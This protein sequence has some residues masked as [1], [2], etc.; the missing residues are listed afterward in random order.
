[1]QKINKLFDIWNKNQSSLNGWL[2]LSN[3]FTAE[4]MSKMGWDSITIDLQHGQND[5]SS[6]IS[7]L[8]AM[9][10]SEAT[11]LVRVPWN[12]PGIIM[13]MLDLG[14]LGVIA[15]MIN[16]KKDCENFVSYCNYP[17]IGQRS[18][19]PMRAQLIYGNEYFADA[20]KNIISFAMIETKEAV[21]NIDE[22]LSVKDL[23]GIYI[24]PADMSSAYG[25]KPKF[26]V[27]DDPVYSNIK[28]IVSKAN[29]MGKIAGIHNG[30]PSYAKE[31]IKLGFKFVTVSS[32]YRSMTSHAQSIVNEMKEKS[33]KKTSSSD[34]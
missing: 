5:Y 34:Y 15:P 14:V 19:G 11:P 16:N 28:E 17:P 25:L 31:M 13:K 33:E 4:A 1:M 12:E 27:K 2:S 8:Q 32:D 20:N 22:I 6:S 7:L 23:T 21:E 10:N 3:S 9:S 24:G 30:T 26:D 29:Q 18:F